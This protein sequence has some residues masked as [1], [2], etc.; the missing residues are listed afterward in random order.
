MAASSLSTTAVSSWTQPRGGEARDSTTRLE[1]KTETSL[2][3][4]LLLVV[5]KVGKEAAVEASARSTEAALKRGPRAMVEDYWHFYFKT[6]RDEPRKREDQTGTS[7][8]ICFSLYYYTDIRASFLLGPGAMSTID[9]FMMIVDR[10]YEQRRKSTVIRPADRHGQGTDVASRQHA[11]LPGEISRPCS[12]PMQQL[13]IV[14]ELW[15]FF[16]NV[17]IPSMRWKV[18]VALAFFFL[19]NIPCIYNRGH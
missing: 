5:K 15:G 10:R 16:A 11:V 12:F 13:V 8:Q 19:F 3:P 6:R 9:R 4:V 18:A 2:L 14:G 17:R 7:W 1:E